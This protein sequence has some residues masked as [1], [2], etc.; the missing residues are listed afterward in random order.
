MHPITQKFGLLMAKYDPIPL[1]DHIIRAVSWT[2]LRKD[3][4]ENVLG[5]L[6]QAFELRDGER[7]LST[8]WREH[9]NSD[10]VQ[11]IAAMRRCGMKLTSKSGLAHANV[12]KVVECGN[13]FGAKLR[14][15]HQPMP[16][17]TGYVAVQNL[18]HE[19]H[20]L[21]EM[22]AVDAVVETVMVGTIEST[23]STSAQ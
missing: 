5:C 14:V 7:Y 12:G 19:D 10:L 20:E 13:R 23:N 3:E 15:L 17:N 21:L 22:L 11:I 4:N 18:P 8:T 1:A 16:E 6:W 2:R 9:F